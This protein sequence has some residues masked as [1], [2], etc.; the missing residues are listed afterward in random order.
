MKKLRHGRFLKDTKKVS[1]ERT[2]QCLKRGHFEKKAEAIMYV[3]K[4]QKLWVNSVVIS[5]V[6]AR[7]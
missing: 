3:G 7:Y 2:W 1:T 6:V 4:E 5:L